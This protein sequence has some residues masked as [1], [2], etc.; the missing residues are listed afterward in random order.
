MRTKRL[1]SVVQSIGHHAVSGLCYIHPHLGEACQRASVLDADV[2]LLSGELL[3]PSSDGQ[4]SLRLASKALGHRF[5][6]VLAS[7]GLE[8]RELKAAF[9]RFQFRKGAWPSGCYVRAETEVGTVVED[10]LAAPSG[11]RVEIRRDAT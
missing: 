11:R 1:R 6:E 5:A 7:E 2:D 8:R 9:V 3:S 4:E 10:A